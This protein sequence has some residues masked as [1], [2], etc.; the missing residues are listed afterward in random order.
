ML[1]TGIERGNPHDEYAVV[2]ILDGLLL[3]E[4]RHCPLRDPVGRALGAFLDGL[5][6]ASA[7]RAATVRGTGGRSGPG[8]K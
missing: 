4:S 8:L 6:D 7:V 5:R 1:S 2:L 3:V